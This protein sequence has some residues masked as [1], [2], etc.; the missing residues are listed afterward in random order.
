MVS[1]L[2]ML[3]HHDARKTEKTSA[4]V[5]LDTFEGAAACEFILLAVRCH[6][7]AGQILI[8][9]RLRSEMV[10]RSWGAMFGRI[11]AR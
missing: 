6:G 9:A 11:H 3:A 7:G 2:A 1:D 5:T 10:P 4:T 8:R